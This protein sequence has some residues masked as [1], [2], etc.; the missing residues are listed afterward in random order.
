MGPGS[1][2]AWIHFVVTDAGGTVVFESGRV[3]GDGSIS[4]NANDVNGSRFEPHYDA[5][6]NPDQVQIYEP[7]LGATDGSTTTVL[8]SASSYLKDNRLL[9]LGFDKETADDEVEVHGG[10][11]TDDDFIGG[12][13]RVRYTVDVSGA[14]GPFI[15]EAKLMYQPIGY[16]W[17]HNLGDQ[18]AEEIERFITHYEEAA[19][20][21]AAM[22]A[23]AKTIV[24]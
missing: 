9:P 14:D 19:E 16:R 6:D 11:R 8:L 4:G 5:I 3:N 22:L 12:S 23:A 10:A 18:E 7:I 17:A 20:R 1:R 21:S 13:D 2:R 15:V 24:E